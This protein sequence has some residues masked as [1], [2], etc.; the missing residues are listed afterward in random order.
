M[1]KNLLKDTLI[2]TASY[3]I[4]QLNASGGYAGIEHGGT[5]IRRFAV[6]SNYQW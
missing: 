5:F 3:S 4:S 1:N 2:G 6:A